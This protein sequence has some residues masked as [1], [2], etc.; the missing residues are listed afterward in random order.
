MRLKFLVGLSSMDLD[1]VR[2]TCVR[3]RS[4]VRNSDCNDSVSR[5]HVYYGV[6]KVSVGNFEAATRLLVDCLQR[7]FTIPELMSP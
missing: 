5:T 2:L 4:C 7:S 1:V 6:Y 3:H